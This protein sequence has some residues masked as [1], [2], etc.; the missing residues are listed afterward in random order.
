[1][2][3]IVFFTNRPSCLIEAYV[4]PKKYWLVFGG[5]LANNLYNLDLIFLSEGLTADSGMS[6]RSCRCILSLAS[7]IL[8][9]WQTKYG[10]IGMRCS[11]DFCLQ[12]ATDREAQWIQ[13]R[14]IW[15]PIRRSPESC[16]QA[17]TGRIWRCRPARNPPK[18][19]FSIGICTLGAGDHMLSQ[20]LL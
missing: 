20:R 18:G 2:D 4:G 3:L 13:V 15:W 10:Q 14:Q 17:A 11:L 9:Q 6:S 1:M 12:N 8:Q 16:Q 5:L 19:I 7:L